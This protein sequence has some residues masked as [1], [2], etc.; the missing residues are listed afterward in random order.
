MV[1]PGNQTWEVEAKK[2]RATRIASK[3]SIGHGW[4]LEPG[5]EARLVEV[6][7]GLCSQDTK[8]KLE[9]CGPRISQANMEE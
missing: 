8:S 6:M 3:A 9:Y 2:G 1:E 5:Y 4:P 7:K